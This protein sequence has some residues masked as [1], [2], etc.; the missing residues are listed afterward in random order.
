M[1][2]I[3]ANQENVR[4]GESGFT[5]TTLSEKLNKNA[6]EPTAFKRGNEKV[7]KSGKL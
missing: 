5:K 1:Q 6:R 7:P 3:K 2:I 4:E